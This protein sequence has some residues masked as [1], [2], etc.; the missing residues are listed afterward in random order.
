M[1]AAANDSRKETRRC[2]KAKKSQATCARST[3]PAG[4]NAQ[5]RFVRADHVERILV[6]LVDV[7]EKAVAVHEHHALRRIAEARK[8]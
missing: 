1:P 7:E 4:T 5:V 6:A 8:A 2:W 3:L